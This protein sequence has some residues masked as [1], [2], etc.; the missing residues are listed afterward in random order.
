MDALNGS[1]SGLFGAGNNEEAVC[2]DPIAK[3]RRGGMCQHV[4]FHGRVK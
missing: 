4:V 2:G 1:T 3:D